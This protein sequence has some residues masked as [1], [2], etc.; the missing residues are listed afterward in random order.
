MLC[1]LTVVAATTASG[2]IGSWFFGAFTSKEEFTITAAGH[3]LS[4]D[5]LVRVA[6][7]QEGEETSAVFTAHKV[8]DANQAVLRQPTPAQRT[9]ETVS[10]AVV[11]M[12]GWA[13]A[14]VDLVASR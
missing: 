14:A 13:T 10:R 5:D 6:A 11:R 2:F 8:V 12:Q 3:G 7:I 9:A 1:T 4:K